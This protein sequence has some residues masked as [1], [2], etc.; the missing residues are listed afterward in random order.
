MKRYGYLIEKI[1]EESNLLEAFS[2]VMRGKKR[3]RTVRYFKKNRDKILADLADEIKSGKYAPEGFR[4]FEVEENG[5]V[6][7]IQSLPFKDRIALHAIMT[8]LY[9]DV[10]GGMM[11]RDTYASLPK[12]GIH[13]GLNRLRKA[14]KDRSNTEYC[15]KL[16]L[17][18]FYHSV[19]Q[20]VLIKRL[21]RKIKDETLMQTLIRIIR[22]YGP[23]LAIGYH[24]SQLLG[25]FYLCLLDHYMK[26]ELGVKYYF[27]YCDDVVVLGPDKAYL[28]GIFAKLRKVVEEELHLTIK[29][30]WQI[31][32]V[33]AR[34]IDFLG[35]VTRHDYVLVRKHI[36]QKVAR[37]LQKVKSK[38]RKYV[39]LAS[40]WGWVK[41][42][43]GKHL[44]FKLTNMKSFKDLGVTYKPAD[45]KK[46]FEGNLTPLGNLQNC[47]VTIVDFETDI[48]T[49]QG[50][51]RYVVQYELDGQK[52]II[53]PGDAGFTITLHVT[54]SLHEELKFLPQLLSGDAVRFED[55][56]QVGRCQGKTFIQQIPDNSLFVSLFLSCIQNLA[57]DLMIF[58]HGFKDLI[59][60]KDT[61]K[62][63][64][65]SNNTLISH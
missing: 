42:C 23:G 12:R 55:I 18:K 33:E 45:G 17:K 32:P 60:H 50:E 64:Y 62:S 47:K 52:A 41:H 28:H 19:D 38:K 44:F 10:L 54:L 6:R 48:K 7:E 9:R 24:S 65:R 39:V 27:R 51:G 46:R 25:N 13:D 59:H 61:S 29:Q 5:K 56:E 57:K 31:F 14:L 16:D 3:S 53:P 2:M 36:K 8:V 11:I 30:N 4:E 15:L 35:Y 34:G 58:V 26:A 40:F 1:V 22:S 37:R 49:K 63:I 21:R 43:N 20:E